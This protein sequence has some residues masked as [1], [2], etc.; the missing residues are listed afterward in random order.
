MSD[1]GLTSTTWAPPNFVGDHPPIMKG[2]VLA[3]TGA[4]VNLVAGTVLAEVAGKLVPWDHDAED[5]SQNPTC[6]LVEDVTV[7]AAGDEK[8]SVYVHGLFRQAGL[9]FD[10]EA[11]SGDV[12]AAVAA[13]ATLGIHIK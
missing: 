2:A 11:E 8:A 9:T 6:I 4:A 5:G 3:S 13:L 10:A 7:P 12:A 1:Y